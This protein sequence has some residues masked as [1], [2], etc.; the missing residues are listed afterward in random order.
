[1]SL[2]N[3]TMKVWGLGSPPVQALLHFFSENSVGR[4]SS[5]K[6]VGRVSIS[7]PFGRVIISEPDGRVSGIFSFCCVS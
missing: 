5:S 3:L 6:S 4:V 1:M 7:E 2:T